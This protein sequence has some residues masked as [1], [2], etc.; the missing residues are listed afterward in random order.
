MLA[1]LEKDFLMG[2]SVVKFFQELSN[3]K[4]RKV[5]RFLICCCLVIASI[6]LFGASKSARMG[7]QIGLGVVGGATGFMVGTANACCVSCVSLVGNPNLKGFKF[8]SGTM[9]TGGLVGTVLGGTAGVYFTGNMMLDE[10]MEL[11]NPWETFFGTMAGGFVSCGVGY[12]LD[13]TMHKIREEDSARPG[14]FYVLGL[15]LSPVAETFAY[16]QF[17]KEKKINPVNVQFSISF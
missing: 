10:G 12:L 1:P 8:L 17:V 7:A 13:F 15:M 2:F 4:G 6:P 9:T 14:S 11:E 3:E 5:K 16:H